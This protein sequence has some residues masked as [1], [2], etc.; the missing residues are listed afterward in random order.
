MSERERQPTD[1][2]AFMSA[3]ITE[4][5]VLQTA[6]S[7]T[8][9]EEGSRATL[10]VM[11]LSSSLVAMGFTVQSS[12]AFVPFVSTVLPAVFLLGVFTIVRLV[13]TGLQNMQLR[14]GMARIRRY[15]RTLSPEAGLYILDW[16]AGEDETAEAVATLSV[17]H[18]R[19]WLIGFFTIASMVAAINSIVAGAGIALLTVG[20]LGDDHVVLA[21]L[22]GALIALAHTG[23]FYAYQRRRYRARL[24]QWTQIRP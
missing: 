19:D 12:H 15:Y 10:Y 17:A 24:E 4:H 7:T 23:T 14:S 18:R 9:S 5:F 6:A 8:V 1:Q 22:L 21:V 3:L 13:D 11:A 20:I 2:S 16:G